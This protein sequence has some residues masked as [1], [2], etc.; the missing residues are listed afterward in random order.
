M[1]ERL[2]FRP[3]I[4]APKTHAH[5]VR[6]TRMLVPNSTAIF[7]LMAFMEASGESGSITATIVEPDPVMKELSTPS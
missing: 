1:P 2:R 6:K 5:P 7:S 4:S 3:A